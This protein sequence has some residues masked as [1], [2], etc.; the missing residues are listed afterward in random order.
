MENHLKEN[1]AGTNHSIVSETELLRK[2]LQLQKLKHQ[3]ELAEAVLNTQEAERLRLGNEL[4]DNV[5][6]LLA[7]ANLC[8]DNLRPLGDDDEKLKQKTKEFIM[9][10]YVEIQMLSRKLASPQLRANS[11][12]KSLEELVNDIRVS[13]KYNIQFDYDASIWVNKSL[14]LIL[15]RIAQEQLKNVIQ[16]SR[17]SSI[18]VEL[19]SANE[20][21][22]LSI[23]DNGI[24]FDYSKAKLGIGLT[25]IFE[26]VK[27]YGG[28]AEL[29]TAPGK[30]CRLRVCVPV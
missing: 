2:E 27:Q 28:T 6:Q 17:A 3:K 26:R 16:Y 7:T 14:R 23:A 10:A 4:H 29:D 5:N 25:N 13:N 24:G 21:V 30:G 20:E 15:Y 8:L 19:K 12:A 1:S 11:I 9:M 18:R 22:I